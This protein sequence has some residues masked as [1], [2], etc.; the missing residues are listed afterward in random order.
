MSFYEQ[1]R[2]SLLLGGAV[3]FFCLTLLILGGGFNSA[4]A[5]SIS[6][7]VFLALEYV[8]FAS[9]VVFLIGGCMRVLHAWWAATFSSSSFGRLK[10]DN[11][12]V[13][14]WESWCGINA[15]GTSQVETDKS[16]VPSLSLT[17]FR[18]FR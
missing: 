1:I 4:V 15:D 17:F 10:G 14:F 8:C 13:R 3:L 7:P 5:L 16:D 11:I 6:E 2:W 9:G 18:V 12:A